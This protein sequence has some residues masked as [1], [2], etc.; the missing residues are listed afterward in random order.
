MAL[1]K[2][3][4]KFQITIPK[5]LRHLCKTGWLF[6]EDDQGII[7]LRSVEIKKAQSDKEI[8]NE[9]TKDIKFPWE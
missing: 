4:P 5:Y 9:L 7:V 2:V 8:M 1:I 3:S 6:I